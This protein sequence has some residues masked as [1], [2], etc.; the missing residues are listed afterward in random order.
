M[1][2]V[3]VDGREVLLVIMATFS[4][5]TTIVGVFMMINE[6]RNKF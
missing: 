5:I 4:V 3:I 1:T 6:R 2:I